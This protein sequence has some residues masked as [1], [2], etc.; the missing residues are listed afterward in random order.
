MTTQPRTNPDV[1]INTQM[2]VV[3]TRLTECVAPALPPTYL[4]ALLNPT[5]LALARRA[6]LSGGK[7]ARRALRIL[8]P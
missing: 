1:L 6:C 2:L 5:R 8:P 4:S 7:A 3:G